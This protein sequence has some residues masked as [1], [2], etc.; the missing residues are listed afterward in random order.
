MSIDITDVD[1]IKFAKVVYS[2]S[3]PQGL[4][5]LHFREGEL[6]DEEA[7]EITE[8]SADSN[9]MALGMDYVRG[10]SCKMTVRKEKGRLKINDQ[11][12]D[13]SQAQL[14]ELLDACGIKHQVEEPPVT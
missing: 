7:K 9:F 3:E 1:L 6:S 12:Y 14:Q 5:L 13:H 11:W 2:L 4:G 10:R 8:R